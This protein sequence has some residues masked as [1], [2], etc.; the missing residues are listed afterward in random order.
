LTGLIVQPRAQADIDEALG[1]YRERDPRLAHRFLLELDVVFDRISQNPRRFP[2]VGDPVQRALL[3]KF[4]F[5]VY[6]VCAGELAAIV[7]VVHQKRRPIE[8]KPRGG[9]AG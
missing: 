8:W 3:R 7:A 4:P 6:F 5:S 1:L 9:G 2:T